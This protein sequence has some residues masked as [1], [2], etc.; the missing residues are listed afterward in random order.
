MLC[1]PT[2]RVEV[3][4][5]SKRQ[6][7]VG[8]TYIRVGGREFYQGAVETLGNEQPVGQEESIGAELF[9][10]DRRPVAGLGEEMMS[11]TDHDY[12]HERN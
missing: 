2:Q 5:R 1:L 9:P 7:G 6:L 4:V 10:G 11:C 8:P 3:P 12:Q